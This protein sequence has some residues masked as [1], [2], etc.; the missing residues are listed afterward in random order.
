[1]GHIVHFKA[2]YVSYTIL[3]FH[4]TLKRNLAKYACMNVVCVVT[5]STSLMLVVLK[6]TLSLTLLL[7]VSSTL[8]RAKPLMCK[9][10]QCVMIYGVNVSR[11]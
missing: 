9:G 6:L 8:A 1:M 11:T 2:L 7:S 10:E 5:C 3:A 4:I